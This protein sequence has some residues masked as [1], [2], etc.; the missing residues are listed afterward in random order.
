MQPLTIWS[1]AH[2]PPLVTTHLEGALARYRLLRPPSLQSLNLVAAPPDPQFF[3]ADVAFGQPDPT[4]VIASTRLKWVHLTSAGY[5]RYDRDDLRAALRSRGVALTTSSHVYDEPCAQHVLAMMMS[6]GRRLP[7]AQDDQRNGRTWPAAPLRAKSN[8]LLCQRVLI[9]GFGTIARRLVELLSPLKMEIIG[10][11]RTPA[12]DEPV[13][14][15]ADSEA[16]DLLPTADHVI[17]IL[18]ANPSTDGHF[19]AARFGRMKPGAIF[20]NIG[21]GTTVDQSALLATLQSGHVA[22]AFLD[23]T[24]PEPL[25][26]DHP[27]WAAPNCFI[28]PHTAGGHATEFDRLAAHFLDNLARFD[29]NDPLI[30]RVI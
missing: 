26:P 8:L 28:T 20:Y 25:P 22:A 18:P 13:Q 7:Y 21:R 16:D 17:N 11:R 1:N 3:E 5:T 10:V 24:D 2:F 15:I 19:T 12:G 4:Q 27:L 14:V 23:V 29:R 9:Y 30:D 6:L